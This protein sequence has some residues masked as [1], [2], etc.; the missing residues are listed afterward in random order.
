[1]PKR[2]I[3]RE[4]GE[5]VRRLLRGG[6]G[7]GWVDVTRARAWAWVVVVI[8]GG[9]SYGA[10][11]GLWRATA[12]AVCLAVKMPLLL[13]L[14]LGLNGLFN[15]MM[16]AVL[17]SGLGFRQT[18]AAIGQSFAVFAL[19][20]GGLGP[21]AAFMTLSLAAGGEAGG[22]KA[23][24]ILLLVHTA[25]IA[26]GGVYANLRL[27]G[28]VE[29]VCGR[30]IGRQVVAAWLAGNLFVGAQL[31]Y[32]LRPFFGN[33]DLPV[34]FLRPNP[35]EGNFYESVWRISRR[36]LWPGTTGPHTHPESNPSTP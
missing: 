27:L 20:M 3:Y 13:G 35:F 24:R 19:V 30:R 16:A 25:L 36:T 9:A 12:Q 17:G 6:G 33:P 29:R 28:G 26:L 15:G 4:V 10:S 8:V 21:V 18:L 2:S 34:Q 5:E 23:Y 1:M 14:T 31:S 7:D 22:D 11:I 32:T